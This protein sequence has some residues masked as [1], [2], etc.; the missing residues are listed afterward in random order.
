MQMLK[1]LQCG[2]YLFGV[3]TTFCKRNE[4]NYGMYLTGDALFIS[5]VGLFASM[6]HIIVSN[7]WNK[8]V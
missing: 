2:V 4:Y 5:P 1:Y 3:T 8:E 7:M 6:L